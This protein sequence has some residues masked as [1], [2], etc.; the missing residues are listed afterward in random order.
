MVIKLKDQELSFCEQYSASYNREELLALYWSMHPRYRFFKTCQDG[1][2]LDVGAGSGGLHFWKR[3]GQPVRE[4]IHM[5]GADRQ[6]GEYADA[7]ED[8]RITDLNTG[9][10]PWEDIMFQNVFVSHVL[11]HLESPGLLLKNLAEQHLCVGGQYT[12]R[13]PIMIL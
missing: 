2:F 9:K 6:K 1:K 3:W 10:L 12:L 13:L 4:G 5:Y 8:F 7:Y 11:E